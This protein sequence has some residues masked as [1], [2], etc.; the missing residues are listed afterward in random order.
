[1]VRYIYRDLYLE[2]GVTVALDQEF[3]RSLI[4]SI[5]SDPDSEEA[6]AEELA[7]IAGMKNPKPDYIVGSDPDNVPRLGDVP[8]PGNVRALLDI[9]Q[10]METPFLIVEGTQDLGSV[11]EAQDQARRGG[12]T[13]VNAARMLRATVEEL[14]DIEGPDE[15]SFVFSFT[16]SPEGVEFWVHWYQGPAEKQFFHMNRIA[17]HLLYDYEDIDGIRQKLHNII[18]W[19]AITRL[20]E[21]QCLYDSIRAYA[22]KVHAKNV[23]AQT[24]KGRKR[25]ADEVEGEF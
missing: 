8:M 20:Y 10:G 22:R 25:K 12:A 11:V 18:E 21:R 24:K 5:H 4:L 3:P 9:C 17:T 15:K 6:M 13:L 2:G 14:P 7:K 16:M 19:G 1:M 23:A